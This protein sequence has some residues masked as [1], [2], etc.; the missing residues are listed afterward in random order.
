MSEIEILFLCRLTCLVCHHR[1]IFDT[2]DMFCVHRQGKKH[3]QSKYRNV[4]KFSDRHVWANSAD[5]DQTAPL[6]RVYTIWHSVCIVWTHSS[7]VEP[8]V[9]ILVI[10]TIFLGNLQCCQFCTVKYEKLRHQKNCHKHPKM[11]LLMRKPVF[12]VFDQVRLKPV[13]SA[14]ETT[15]VFW[16]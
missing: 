1:P 15:R 13:C 9:Q 11:S 16:I 8:L 3:T 7:M 5:P 4:L 12:G 14:T 2:L 10:T 6:I